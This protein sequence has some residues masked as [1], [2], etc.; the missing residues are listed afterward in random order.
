MHPWEPLI[1]QPWRGFELFQQ[2]EPFVSNSEKMTQTVFIGVGL[3]LV[4][5]VSTILFVWAYTRDKMLFI[6]AL[7]LLM[8]AFAANVLVYFAAFN[9]RRM[10]GMAYKYY[11]GLSAFVTLAALLLTVLFGAQYLHRSSSI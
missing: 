2:R 6:A 5:I 11:V 1:A 8:F 4:A 10:S 9:R 3:M 7:S